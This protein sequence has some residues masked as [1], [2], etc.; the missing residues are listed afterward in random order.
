MHAS[1]IMTRRVLTVSPE[2]SVRHA[3][4]L[5]IDNRIS[6]LPVCNDEGS[7][8]G[9]LSEG[10]LLRRSELGSKALK[11]TGSRPQ[12]G[13]ETYIKAHSWRVGDVMTKDPVTVEADASVDQIAA[14]MATHAIKRVPV[15]QRGRL[16]G[17]VS[18]RDILQVVLSSKPERFATGD[19]AIR[20][21][22]MARLLSDLNLDTIDVK[23]EGG[24]VALCGN[25]ESGVKR[26]AARV[27][28]EAVCGIGGVRNE[29][30]VINEA[31]CKT[32]GH[33]R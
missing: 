31:D 25:V 17:V 14:L 15:V 4:R 1:D 11:E 21:A 13:L 10:D 16:L 22:V 5:M 7:L 32:S 9:I 3:A 29:L 33:H 28:A 23:V 30:R 27:A 19:E 12:Q 18:R 24:V 8:V 2:H 26:L 6:G 20:R